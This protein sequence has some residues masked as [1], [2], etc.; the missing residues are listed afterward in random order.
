MFAE[1]EGDGQKA[2]RL[3][4]RAYALHNP[5]IGYAFLTFLKINADIAR[6]WE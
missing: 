3:I 5:D 2:L 4:L 6:E 1:R